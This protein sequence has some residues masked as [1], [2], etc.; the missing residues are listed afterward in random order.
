MREHVTLAEGRT[1]V[2]VVPF[3]FDPGWKVFHSWVVEKIEP[4][5]NSFFNTSDARSQSLG[6][7]EALHS[8]GCNRPREGKQATGEAAPD[9]WT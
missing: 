5:T 2:T 9:M 1:S 6:Y 8:R 3:S 7:T 4:P